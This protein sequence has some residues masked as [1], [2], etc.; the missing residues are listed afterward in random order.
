MAT[1]DT[2]LLGW[3]VTGELAFGLK[4]GALEVLTKLLIYYFHERAWYKFGYGI[5]RA[6]ESHRDNVVH[7]RE[8]K[9]VNSADNRSDD[10]VETGERH[11]G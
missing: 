10:K 7:L 4:I 3:L 1:V 9:S 6:S 8:L 5:S 2:I 11:H